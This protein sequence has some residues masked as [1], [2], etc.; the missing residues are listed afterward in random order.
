MSHFD[1]KELMKKLRTR[2]GECVECGASEA[3]GPCDCS[4]K[5]AGV[6]RE[7]RRTKMV[8][9]IELICPCCQ[10]EIAE[11]STAIDGEEDGHPVWKH[12]A[13]G[14]RFRSS[15]EAER[16]AAKF[17]GKHAA[18]DPEIRSSGDDS[19]ANGNDVQQPLLRNPYTT[20]T[21]SPDPQD[22]MTFENG[23][24]FAQSLGHMQLNQAQGQIASWMGR[25]KAWRDGFAQAARGMGCGN[26]ADQL[27]ASNKIAQKAPHMNLPSLPLGYN[28]KIAGALGAL[29]G[30]L[31]GMGAGGVGGAMLGGTFGDHLGASIGH[32]AETRGELPPEMSGHGGDVGGA[33]GGLGGGALGLGVGGVVGGVAGA[34]LGDRLT[35]RR[36][37]QPQ[38]VRMAALEFFKEASALG[39]LG[40]G[41]LGIGVGGVAGGGLGALEGFTAA[42]LDEAGT[43]NHIDNVGHSV[44]SAVDP[45]RLVGTD[46]DFIANAQSPAYD[47]TGYAGAV[48]GGGIGA[49]AGAGIGGVVGAASAHNAQQPYPS[50]GDHKMAALEFFEMAQG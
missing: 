36:Q 40:G 46:Q 32:E 23:Y 10:K 50:M 21:A 26:I 18:V 31:I 13:C 4:S 19:A 42:N 37:D 15:E 45:L 49:L 3:K 2:R 39:T 20:G 1:Y 12:R 43:A 47:H 6:A 28:D 9:Q 16:E 30:G 24:Q 22:A 27:D 5:T 7:I 48:A 14:G 11:K 35:G 8:P 17:F 29:G 38:M 33:L 34:N 25:P 41:L 44:V